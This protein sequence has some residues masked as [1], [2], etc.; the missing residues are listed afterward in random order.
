MCL[1]S[2][3]YF[4]GVCVYLKCYLLC[5]FVI[6]MAGS[7]PEGTQFDTRQFDQKLNEV[8][9]FNIFDLYLYPCVILLYLANCY[10]YFG[11]AWR[12]RTSSSPRMM[13]S[14]RAL[15]PWVSKR[16]FLGASML[17]VSQE[18]SSQ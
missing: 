14:M 2:L 8:Q 10:L 6:V 9:V 16:T 17:M 5:V 13:R 18:E 15:M 1:L 3:R 7:A 11:A 4:G 12:D